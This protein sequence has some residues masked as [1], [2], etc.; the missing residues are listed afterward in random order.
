MWRAGTIFAICLWMLCCGC[1]KK[2][3]PQT[4]C[5]K[6]QEIFEL[7]RGHIPS[8]LT[9][10]RF[11]SSVVEYDKYFKIVTEARLKIGDQ[12]S[13]KEIRDVLLKAAGLYQKTVLYWDDAHMCE[14][15]TKE[16]KTGE[17]YT[18]RGH[19]RERLN[20][21]REAYVYIKSM[22]PAI[23]VPREIETLIATGADTR[24][25]K[26]DLMKSYMSRAE[27]IVNASKGQ[28]RARR[29][30]DLRL[31]WLDKLNNTDLDTV[32]FYIYSYE[33]LR[34]LD[35]PSLSSIYADRLNGAR[36]NVMG[37]CKNTNY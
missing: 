37:Y 34:D 32:T 16:G 20:D 31:E 18:Y 1:G 26:C 36:D 13:D 11:P 25:D 21:I 33:Q 5:E 10:D 7:V 15:L 29:L 22:C 9:N 35:V 12:Y 4:R 24:Q 6:I 30:S 19:Q 3:T 14:L 2:A 28:D 23:I 17:I 8:K 27:S